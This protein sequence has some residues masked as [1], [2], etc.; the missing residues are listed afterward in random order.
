VGLALVGVH[1]NFFVGDAVQ[2]ATH[3]LATILALALDGAC[4]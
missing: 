2:S 4:E 1:G 3:K